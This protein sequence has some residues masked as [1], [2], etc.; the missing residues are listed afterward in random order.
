MSPTLRWPEA[1]REL[2]RALRGERSR[3]A[4]ARRVGCS[5]N[6]IYLWE[7]GRRTPPAVAV[8]RG[9]Q[10]SGFDVRAALGAAFPAP[11]P[12]IGSL[13]ITAPGGMP[14]YL[15]ALRGSRRVGEIAAAAGVPREAA[16]RW[17]SGRATPR[18]PA[19]LAYVHAAH[20]R[21]MDLLVALVPPAELPSIHSAWGA[22]EGLRREVIGRP[23]ILVVLLVLDLDDYRALPAHERGWIARRVRVC[24]EEEDACVELL[25]RGGLIA[26]QGA[27]LVSRRPRSLSLADDRLRQELLRWYGDR[28][29]GDLSS[30]SVV[31]VSGERRAALEA[32]YRSYTEQIRLLTSAPSSA[33]HL[34]ILHTRLSA[35]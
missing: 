20:D 28:A 17:R 4:F 31:S 1:T 3:E 32:L 34:M 14:R 7:T 25:L 12:W 6:A 35:F 15:D 21:A 22:I 26:W 18:M 5:A 13:E 2:V 30:L 19:F 11:P 8:L 24:V 16:S 33:E 29:P 27:H 9:A 23:W 10:R